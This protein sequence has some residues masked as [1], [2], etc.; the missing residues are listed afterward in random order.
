MVQ[1]LDDFLKGFVGEA[2]YTDYWYDEGFSIAQ[3][4]LN[5]FE[6]TDWEQLMEILSD[7]NT[8]WKQKLAY[9]L[10]DEKNSYQLKILLLF[11][12]SEDKELI[13]LTVDSLRT[14][15]NQKNKSILL[16]NPIFMDQIKSL[17]E[18][19]GVAVKGIIE[20]LLKKME[21]TL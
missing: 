10:D 5:E 8:K 4:I 1:K 16:E 18:C 15:I 21:I 20:D 6:D 17:Y 11:L 9:C 19:S 13:E 12:E 7:R 3:D 2:D 14:F